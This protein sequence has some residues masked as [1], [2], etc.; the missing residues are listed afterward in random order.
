M[1]IGGRRKRWA[2]LARMAARA[3]F[4]GSARTRVSKSGSRVTSQYNRPGSYQD[5]VKDFERLQPRGQSSFNGRISGRTG[6][7]GNHRVT[8]RDGSS[9]GQPTLEI[10]SPRPDGSTTVRKFRY[11]KQQ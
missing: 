8:V 2:A 5:A 6:T 11:D 3:L 9:G 4:R 10:R 7:V 1:G